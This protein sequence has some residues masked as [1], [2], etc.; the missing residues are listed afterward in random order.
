MVDKVI[1]VTVGSS[2]REQISDGTL[3]LHLNHCQ[4]NIINPWLGIAKP[5]W[6]NLIKKSV[7]NFFEKANEEANRQ[8]DKQIGEN[9]I[10][11]FSRHKND[12][13]LMSQCRTVNQVC[14][15]QQK[16]NSNDTFKL[17]RIHIIKWDTLVG[18]HYWLFNMYLMRLIVT[19]RQ[20]SKKKILHS[21]INMVVVLR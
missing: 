11:F 14:C 4:K 20:N 3:F 9:I 10:S 7:H 21:N 5:I 2:Q 1:R 16:E 8:T 18:P 19:I 12:A 6:E 15:Q 13:K 17:H